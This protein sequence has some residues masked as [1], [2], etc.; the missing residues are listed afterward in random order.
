M[1]RAGL[2]YTIDVEMQQSPKD[3]KFPSFRW[4]YALAIFVGW[5]F[6]GLM[7]SVL[8]LSQQGNALNQANS[9]YYQYRSRLDFRIDNLEQQLNLFLEREHKPEAISID[10]MGNEGAIIVDPTWEEMTLPHKLTVYAVNIASGEMF[11]G[12]RVDANGIVIKAPF[13]DYH[14]FAHKIYPVSTD[15]G[16]VDDE[17][18]AAYM[19]RLDDSCN[20]C[21]SWELRPVTLSNDH[22]IAF[23]APTVQPPKEIS[24]SWPRPQLEP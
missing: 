5:I 10:S 12:Q 20:D 14:V 21:F 1:V 2:C 6:V 8:V 3:K 18:I 22:Q 7:I 16:L 9:E 19:N 17:Y 15:E 24:D 11:F 13:G 4:G 23:A